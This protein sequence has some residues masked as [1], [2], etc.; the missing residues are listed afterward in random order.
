VNTLP[1]ATLEAFRDHG[2]TARTVDADVEGA[3]RTIAEVERAGIS[4]R[5]VTDKLLAEGLRSFEKSFD[6]LIG[7]L[8]KKAREM[9]RSTVSAGRE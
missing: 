4:L 2:V 3:R 5:E 9:G 7:G 6:T 8:E 1:P